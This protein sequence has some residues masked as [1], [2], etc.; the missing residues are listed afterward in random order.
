MSAWRQWVEHPEKVWVRRCL[1]H[2][3][4]WVGVAVGLHIVLM[5]ITGSLIVFRNELD[6]DTLR[7]WIGWLVNLHENLL[8]GGNGRFVNGIGASCVIVVKRPHWGR[9]MVA[10]SEQLGGLH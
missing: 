6:R 7:D 5:S 4:L 10:R 3:H 9:Y 1:F 2:V 8:F